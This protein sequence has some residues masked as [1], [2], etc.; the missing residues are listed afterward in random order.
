MITVGTVYMKSKPDMR[1][2]ILMVWTPSPLFAKQIYSCW[3]FI[4]SNEF[5]L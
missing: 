5:V 1:N 4:F 3:V 2:E